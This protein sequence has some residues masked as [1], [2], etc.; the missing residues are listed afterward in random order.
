MKSC[1]ID[2]FEIL[3]DVSTIKI[4]FGQADSVKIKFTSIG[5]IGG[6]GGGGGG[7]TSSFAV[8]CPPG[9]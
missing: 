3:K 8:H 9:L 6:G 7:L 2:Y 4:A 1:R 5:G